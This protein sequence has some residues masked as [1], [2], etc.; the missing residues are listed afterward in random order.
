MKGQFERLWPDGDL[1]KRTFFKEVSGPCRGCATSTE[2]KLYFGTDGHFHSKCAVCQK[3][4][5][6]FA[7]TALIVGEQRRPCPSCAAITDQFRYE[8]REGHLYLM[9]ASCGAE[10]TAE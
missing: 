6:S 7:P 1:R 10:F 9:C 2:H 8:S 5:T 4:V 3:Q